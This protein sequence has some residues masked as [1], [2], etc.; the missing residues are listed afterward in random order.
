[1]IVLVLAGIFL[2]NLAPAFTPPTWMALSYVQ[3]MYQPNPLVL[4]SGGAVAATC[5][6]LVLARL[7]TVFLRNGLLLERTV[8]NVDVIKDQLLRHRVMSFGFFLFYAFGPLPSNQVFIAYGLTGLP[9]RLV[10]PPF[11]IGRLVSYAFWIYTASEVSHRLAVDSLRTARFFGAYFVI[12]QVASLLI[13]Y[14]FARIDWKRVFT[15]HRVHW[16]R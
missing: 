15:D 1:M 9:L 8:R 14:V 5:G 13:V 7:S 4:A 11:L 3:V 6:R 2:L 10:A 16:L 12:A